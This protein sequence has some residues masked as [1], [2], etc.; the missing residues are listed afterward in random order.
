KI[1]GSLASYAIVAGQEIVQLLDL[2]RQVGKLMDDDIRLEILDRRSESASVEDV[3]QDGSDARDAQ[4]VDLRPRP[5]HGRD[6]VPVRQHESQQPDA[7]EAGSARQED[8]HARRT[9]HADLCPS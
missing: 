7:Y 1:P 2:V 3:A 6:Y 5:R 9:R 8:P 4:S